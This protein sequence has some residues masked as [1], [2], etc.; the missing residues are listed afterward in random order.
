MS[1]TVEVKECRKCGARERDKN[2]CCRPC[3][4]SHTRKWREKNAGAIQDYSKS[5]YAQHQQRLLEYAAKYRQ[6]DKSDV[7]IAKRKAAYLIRKPEMLRK[8]REWR[9]NSPVEYLLSVAKQRA[10]RAEMLFNLDV[11]DI[12]VPE[13]CPLL[14]LRLVPFGGKRTDATPSL[15]RIDSLLGYVKGN[16]WVISWRANRLKNDATLD[17]LRGIVAGL[18]NVTRL[19]LVGS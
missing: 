12:V 14:G 2:G 13:R 17:E 4:R 3:R 15:D 18:E 11:T 1:D 6:S 16:V 10:R 7:V 8:T 5:Y 19:R 9:T